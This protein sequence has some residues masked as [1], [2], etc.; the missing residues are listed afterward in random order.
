M[1]ELRTHSPAFPC[2]NDAEKT[3]NWIY[4]GMTLRDYFAAKAIQ[5]MLSSTIGDDSWGTPYQAAESAY[6][7]ADALLKVRGK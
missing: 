3:Y 6:V 7:Y 4:H 1:S 5:G 2:A